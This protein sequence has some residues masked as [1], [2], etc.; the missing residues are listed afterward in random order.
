VSVFVG[1]DVSK[2]RLD[3]C[4]STGQR[5]DCPNTEEAVAAL[6]A[7]L[8]PLQ[9]QTIVVE[10]TGR[11]EALAVACLWE[12]QLPIAVVNPRQVPPIRSVKDAATLV[13]AGKKPRVAL[14]ASMRK[15]LAILNA[16]LRTSEPWRQLNGA[17]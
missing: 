2:D 9:P 14:L 16:M 4:V 15:L 10:A 11:L 3:V 12:A 6:V 13:H 8:R 5:L 7:Q 1:I 17:T